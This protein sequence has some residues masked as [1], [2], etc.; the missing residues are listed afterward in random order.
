MNKAFEA[1]WDTAT[2]VKATGGHCAG[3]WVAKGVAIDTRSLQPGQ[4][5][6]ALK[7]E[8]VDGHDYVVDALAKGAAAAIVESIPEGID[9]EK[10]LVVED[11]YAALEALGIAGRARF[12]GRM[13]GVTGSVGKTSTKE[14]LRLA[15]SAH[16]SVFASHGNF[17]NHIGTPLNLSNL[18]P[19]VDFAVC[20]MGMNH[21]GEIHSLTRQVIPHVA[22]VTNVETVHL[23]FFDGVEGIADAKAEIFEA[24][25]SPVMAVLNADN[26]YTPRVAEHARRCG[27]EVILTFGEA[28]QADVRLT[29]YRATTQGLE[30]QALVMGEEI[31]FTMRAVGKH[32]AITGLIALA[33]S[34]ALG[35]ELARTAGALAEYRELP[36]R[37]ALS[38]IRVNG[39]EALMLDDS[40][41]ASPA[42]MKAAFAKLKELKEAGAIQ[43][44]L[45]VALGEM[46]ELGETAPALHAALAEDLIAMGADSVFTACPLMQ[47]LFDA[48]PKDMRGA[49]AQR[50]DALLPELCAV[51]QPDDVVLV[52]GSHGSL[53]YQLAAALNA[54]AAVKGT[55]YAV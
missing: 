53:M 16:G 36:G 5:Y 23:E 24:Q 31:S 30:A 12:S 35:L 54:G 34:H 33:V 8:R 44:R 45:L 10:L 52:K 47:H 28:A 42:A 39:G 17:N 19:S 2:A 9:P 6:V 7:G 15:L 26:A 48:L 49:H 27:V 14:L 43:G 38:T 11:T 55:R 40:Y 21:A 18:P 25:P 1:N 51:I 22:V 20:E 41:N 3:E 4:L 37:G 50:A 46:R 13:V 29:D 32:W